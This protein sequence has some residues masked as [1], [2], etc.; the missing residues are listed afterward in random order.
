MGPTPAE[1]IIPHTIK[2]PLPNFKVFLTQAEFR[3][4]TKVNHIPLF[5]CP[6]NMLCGEIKTYLLIFLKSKI[7]DM[8]PEPLIFSY[9][10]Y[11][12]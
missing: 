8:E 5:L 7:C 10:T 6:H 4:I 3:F 2:L 12:K 9:L 11:E 1:E